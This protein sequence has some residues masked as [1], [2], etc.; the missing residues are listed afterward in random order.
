MHWE[1]ELAR[2]ASTQHSLVTWNQALAAGLDERTVCRWLE[3]GR[4]VQ[5]QDGVFALAGVPETKEQRLWAAW[6]AAGPNAV[7]S[8]RTAASRWDPPGRGRDDR[9]DRSPQ[10]HA[11]AGRR[12]PPP[13]RRH[14]T[15]PH[16]LA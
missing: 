12:H 1:R 14:A 10:P 15:R 9:A 8:H 5:R 13:P 16:P 11:R 2:V 7:F 6:L 4:L 3:R